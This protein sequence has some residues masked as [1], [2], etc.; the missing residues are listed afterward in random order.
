MRE[1]RDLFDRNIKFEKPRPAGGVLLAG[2]CPEARA[3]LL[4]LSVRLQEALLAEE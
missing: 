1:G 2:F 4:A 3:A